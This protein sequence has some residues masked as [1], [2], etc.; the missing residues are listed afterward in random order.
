MINNLL[1]NKSRTAII[2]ATVFAMSTAIAVMVWGEESSPSPEIMHEYST[3][4][5]LN[6]SI[7]IKNVTVALDTVSHSESRITPKFSYS[8]TTPGVN[9]TQLLTG[10]SVT[11][12]DGTIIYPGTEGYLLN[13]RIPGGEG[14]FVD[15]SLGSYLVPADLSGKVTINLGTAYKTAMA[16]PANDGP[17]IIP[18]NTEFP[19]GNKTYIISKMMVFPA[20]FR[21]QVEPLNEAARKTDL[22]KA[23]LVDNTG[24][25][26][27]Y[28]GGRTTYDNLLPKGHQMRQFIFIGIIPE[29][30]TSLTLTIQGGEDI[31]GPFVFEN[32]HVVSETAPTENPQAPGDPAEG[33]ATPVI[34]TEPTQTPTPSPTTTP[35]TEPDTQ[36]TE[37]PTPS[38]TPT[39][40]PSPTSTPTPTS[41]PESPPS[42]GISGEADTPTPIATSTPQTTPTPITYRS[43]GFAFGKARVDGGNEIAI[44]VNEHPITYGEIAEDK[45]RF[46]TN[47]D[48]MRHW[49]DT[50]VPNGDWT[51]PQGED[52]NNPRYPVQSLFITP[53]FK[54]L[55]RI[56]ESYSV[57]AAVIGGIIK[58]YALY[59]AAIKADF[60]ASEDEISNF[61]SEMRSN[62]EKASK[63]AEASG[64]GE[65]IGY[66]EAVGKDKYWNDIY[67]AQVR[68][69]FVITKWR[70][71]AEKEAYG[72]R[73]I[74]Y[75]E[76]ERMYRTLILSA[77]ANIN[78]QIVDKTMFDETT[79][80]Q[81]LKYAR[82]ATDALHPAQ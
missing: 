36:P 72:D 5:T 49:I 34:A 3:Q 63:S 67:P 73:A 35:A 79:I 4:Q 32:V 26:Y 61:I 53:E 64:I 39:S 40:T 38:T 21:L 15:I 78:I 80:Q 81:A 58:E 76:S 14:E 77:L 25:P 22:G 59:D 9:P 28:I 20:E 47:R 54:E 57:N 50:A 24:N 6:R 1:N 71:A 52:L 11:R 2:L 48:D 31:I 7:T 16:N 43:R 46:T 30:K 55:V 29:S 8:S 68:R 82:D 19:I 18:L 70:Q 10:F 74:S 60:S 65:L 23:T 17:T 41:T 13:S 62:Y 42:G 51:P 33:T 75:K 12:T 66:T 37:T 44:R 69:N 45:V 27:K 56:K